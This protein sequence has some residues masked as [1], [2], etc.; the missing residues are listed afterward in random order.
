MEWG[1]GVPKER[2]VERRREVCEWSSGGMGECARESIGAPSMLRLMH[3]AVV[4]VRMLRTLD[5]SWWSTKQ[6]DGSGTGCV[7]R[8]RKQNPKAT[9]FRNRLYVWALRPRRAENA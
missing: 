8:T 7:T 2:E 6:R 9:H 1:K 4:L 5:L 3:R